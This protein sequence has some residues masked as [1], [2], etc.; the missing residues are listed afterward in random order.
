[1]DKE[2]RLARGREHYRAKRKQE[3]YVDKQCRLANHRECDRQRYAASTIEQ[4]CNS[5]QRRRERR[6]RVDDSWQQQHPN[7]NNHRVV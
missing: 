6:L 5:S 3:N 2:Q 7:D 4:R 1:M